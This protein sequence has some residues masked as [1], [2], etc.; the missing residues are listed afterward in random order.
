MLR[1]LTAMRVRE[2]R[3]PG[4]GAEVLLGSS[5]KTV[6]KR[7]QPRAFTPS[8]GGLRSR[9]SVVRIHCGA[10][11]QRSI[12]LGM[13]EP[14]ARVY[15]WGSFLGAPQWRQQTQNLRLLILVELCHPPLPRLRVER[16]IDVIAALREQRALTPH[17]NPCLSEW[18]TITPAAASDDART[19]VT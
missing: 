2:P 13:A 7:I 11:V 19:A 4:H 16:E 5:P 9:R 14:R 8:I 3:P 10:L 6:P 1:E 18:K 15:L 17:Q 12:G